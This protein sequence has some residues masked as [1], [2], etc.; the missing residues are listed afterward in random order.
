MILDD[1]V[2]AKMKELARCKRSVSLTRMKERAVERGASTLDFAA[3][4]KGEGVQLIAE[5]KRSS[6]SRGVLRPDL[7][8]VELAR[9]YAANGAAAVSVLTEEQYF[10]GS[11]EQLAEVKAAVASVP[12]L[13]KDFIFEP[14]QIYESRACGADAL[15]LIAAMLSSNQLEELLSLGRAL[16]MRCLVEVHDEEELE[17]ALSCGAMIIGIN[18]RDL[19]TF[20]VDLETT[21]RLRPL[22]PPDRIVVSESGIRN[23]D[24][25]ENLRAWGVD[26]VLVGETL[27][28]APDVA[29]KMRELL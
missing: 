11:P 18:N 12:V 15:L 19:R 10:G 2:K 1:I 4:L 27:I 29:A 20:K 17:R 5:V 22:I 7:D 21:G 16:G 25:M 8:H 13:R 24:D 26:A 14:Y 23:R 28:T 9:T 3:A 6:P